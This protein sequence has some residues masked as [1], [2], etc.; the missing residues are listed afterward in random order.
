MY[1]Y[2]SFIENEEHVDSSSEVEEQEE[3][4]SVETILDK[5]IR[6]GKVEYL[7]KWYGYSDLENTWEPAKNLYC[8]DLIIDFE[9]KLKQEKKKTQLESSRN[10]TL[11]SSTITSCV[12]SDAGPSKESKR[13]CP[14]KIKAEEYDISD[15]TDE[16]ENA[17]NFND[18]Q[19]SVSEDMINDDDQ[20]EAPTEKIP[21]KI[22][23]AT[24]A[25]D[26]LMFILKYK[27]I[28]ECD[29]IPS[30]EANLMCPQIVIQFY[31]NRL[32]WHAPKN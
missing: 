1:I 17:I 29:L 20:N 19:N 24:N 14:T 31:E 10:C 7:L 15:K 28:D 23:G 6:N 30:T 13:S 25:K 32:T 3:E 5:R 18:E 4:Y 27:G 2:C 8:E 9:E 26:H 22:I 12:S 16:I 11:S 21:E